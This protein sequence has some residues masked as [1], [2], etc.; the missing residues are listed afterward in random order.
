MQC[1]LI[2]Q[3]QMHMLSPLVV[4]GR[5]CGQVGRWASP[6][7]QRRDCGRHTGAC[8]SRC[9]HQSVAGGVVVLMSIFRFVRQVGS[10]W[11]AI[12]ILRPASSKRPR[13]SNH[14][15][16]KPRSPGPAHYQR[17]SYVIFFIKKHQY[18]YI[19]IYVPRFDIGV[20]IYIYTHDY[21]SAGT[22]LCFYCQNKFIKKKTQKC[23][24]TKQIYGLYMLQR[25]HIT[26]EATT[27]YQWKCD[28]AGFSP[29]NFD[30]QFLPLN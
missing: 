23:F 10:A 1:H 24:N 30:R 16:A 17:Q 29:S 15:Y 13:T 25:R 20:Y 19:Y 18:I 2:Q 9:S 5:R 28:L 14:F 26:A 8:M 7:G 21:N 27:A 6:V 22:C 12:T 11:D 3:P 4:Q